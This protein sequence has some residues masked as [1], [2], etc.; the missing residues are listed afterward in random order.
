MEVSPG[1]ARVIA[2][3]TMATTTMAVTADRTQIRRMAAG[4]C[5]LRAR[6]IGLR[7]ALP[8]PAASL[9]RLSV[10]GLWRYT[11]KGDRI[12]TFRR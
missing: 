12:V 5:R 4:M 10:S 3:G 11:F 9:P 1:A 2:A 7:E 6:T 8:N